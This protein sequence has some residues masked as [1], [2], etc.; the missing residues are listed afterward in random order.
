MNAFKTIVNAIIG[1]INKVVAVPFNAI[2]GAIRQLEGLIFSG[3][4]RSNG[5]AKSVFLKSR[6]SQPVA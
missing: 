2:N 5:L 6:S 1:G 3:S 4:S